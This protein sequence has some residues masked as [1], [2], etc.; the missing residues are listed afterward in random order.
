M[1][2]R[3]VGLNIAL[4]VSTLGEAANRVLK[5][6]SRLRESLGGNRYDLGEWAGAFGDLGTLV[7]FVLAYITI[8]KMDPG[9]LLFTFGVA[10]IVTG[11]F[12]KTPVPV[13]PMK[14]IGI[15]AVAGVGGF[16]PSSVWGAGLATGLIW[17]FLGLTGLI[18]RV[19]ALAK[20]PVVQGIVLGL[21]LTF[22]LEGLRSMATNY[23]LAAAGFILTLALLDNR[24]FPA[25]F[26]LLAL[27]MATSLVANPAL[28]V[29]VKKSVGFSLP[30]FTLNKLTWPEL[31][32]GSLLLALPQV[33]LTLGNAVI[34]VVAENNELFPHRPLSARRIALSTGLLNLWAPLFGG[35]PM[36]HGAGGM[37]GHVR[38]GARTGGALVILGS[39]VLVV[40]LFLARGVHLIFQL[41]PPAVLGVILFFAGAELAVTAKPGSSSR[42]EFFV[43]LVT[44]AFATWNMGVAFLAGSL[45][46]LAVEKGWIK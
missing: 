5:W 12:Y 18:D 42:E 21:G 39:L 19:T 40:A 24:K 1:L 28:L 13:Q 35:V 23:F 20:R 17:L 29:E 27:G 46:S 14:A 33:P 38:F 34:A 45:L 32:K 37:A 44:A 11:L 2:D 26:L 15:S 22:M 4:Q 30:S 41:F 9:G 16:T 43:T 25:M 3:Y 6:I 36:C 31:V 10:K 8:L 7:P